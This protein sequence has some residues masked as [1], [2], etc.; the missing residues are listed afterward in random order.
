MKIPWL[1]TL[2]EKEYNMKNPMF[3]KA[4]QELF[5][6]EG[7]WSDDP[8]D[9][10]GKTKY[11]ITEAVW[12]E[13]HNGN[14][15]YDIS[16]ITR[17]DAELVYYHLYWRPMHLEELSETLHQPLVSE[18]FES[19]VNHGVGRATIFIQASFNLIKPDNK[20]PLKEDGV[21]GP[22]TISSILLMTNHYE[23]VLLVAYHGERYNFY[24]SIV[25]KKPSQL[26]F[27]K[28]WLRRLA[29]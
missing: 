27:I 15:P 9:P 29:K 13:F 24:K 3:Q 10:G 6:I 25:E 7:G 4:L 22:L 17:T 28:G 11:G 2:F 21:M 14:P 18:M 1:L 19:A 20:A 16:R 8:D 23:D 26:K 5:E 12:K